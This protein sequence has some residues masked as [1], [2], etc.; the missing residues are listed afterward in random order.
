MINPFPDEVSQG[1]LPHLPRGIT[2]RV[3]GSIG[4]PRTSAGE[5]ANEAS[6]TPQSSLLRTRS[7]LVFRVHT[8]S[9]QSLVIGTR[10]TLVS[11]SSLR[12]ELTVTRGDEH[13]SSACGLAI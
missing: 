8:L 10:L 13:W 2:I 5:A 11:L 12:I 3:R 6:E 4:T 9:T 7:R 1:S